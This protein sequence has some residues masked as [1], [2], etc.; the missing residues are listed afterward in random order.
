MS[1]AGRGRGKYAPVSRDRGHPEPSAQVWYVPV[2]RDCEV[3]AGEV[4]AFQV[5]W[6]EVA[7]Y[8]PAADYDD[9]GPDAHDGRVVPCRVAGNALK[10]VNAA[11]T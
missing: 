3:R 2:R 10:G 6:A 1:R 11:P 4:C 5:D 9:S 8:G 7:V